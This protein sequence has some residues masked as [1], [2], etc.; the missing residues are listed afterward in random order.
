[1]G[2]SFVLVLALALTACATKN[3]NVKVACIGDSITE[4]YAI[5]YQSVNSY[6]AQLAKQL[7]KGYEVMNFGR[8][9]TTMMTDGDVPYWSVSEYANA[10]T[11]DANI[12]VIKLGTNDSKTYQWNADKFRQS[13]QSMIDTLLAK[14]PQPQIKLCTPVPA[15]S[16]AWEISDSVIVGSVIPI[17]NDLA[18]R[19]NLQVI[20]L[21]TP[22]SGHPELFVEDGIHPNEDGAKAIAEIVAK[23]IKKD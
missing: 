15:Y 18:A 13:Y 20:D 3:D 11:Y 17:V 12:V 14:K 23:T 16:H 6:P 10:M 19:N 22:M 2:K 9:S 4:G 5:E 7:G 8:C 21:Y 1:M